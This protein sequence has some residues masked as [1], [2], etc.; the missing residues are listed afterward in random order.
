MEVPGQAPS[1]LFLKI[2]ALVIITR[3]VNL[4]VGVAN[5]TKAIVRGISRFRVDL[6]IITGPGKGLIFSCPRFNMTIKRPAFKFNRLQFPLRL[7][8]ASTVHKAQGCTLSLAV[9]DLRMHASHHGCLYTAL[10]R[11]KLPEHLFVIPPLDGFGPVNFIIPKFLEA[12][13]RL[14]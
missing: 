4:A 3:N 6:E 10:S 11:V 2:G 9:I 7:C 14:S 5:G 1:V 8:Y 13:T 12:I